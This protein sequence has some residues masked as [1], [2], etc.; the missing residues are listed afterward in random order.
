VCGIFGFYNY[1]QS[2]SHS[3][4]IEILLTGLRRLEYRGYDSAG[5]AVDTTP[6]P[7]VVVTTTPHNTKQQ[8]NGDDLSRPLIIKACGKISDLETQVKHDLSE[9]RIDGNV[10]FEVHAGIAHT[11]WAT[12]GPPSVVNAHPH[13]SGGEAHEFLVVHNGIITNFRA[14]KDFLVHHGETFESETDTEVIPKL[15]KWV[16]NSLSEPISFSQVC[17]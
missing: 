3:D 6:V 9:L 12:H 5:L 17:L 16:Y 8:E 15:F 11:R 14:L 10:E 7:L 13:T 1:R 2:R 4:I